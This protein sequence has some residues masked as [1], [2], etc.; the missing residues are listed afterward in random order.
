MPSLPPAHTGQIAESKII[1]LKDHYETDLGPCVR[2]TKRGWSYASVSIF[3][4][5]KKIQGA[6]LE[7]IWTIKSKGTL[8]TKYLAVGCSKDPP[9]VDKNPA[10]S[11]T[12]CFFFSRNPIYSR[13]SALCGTNLGLIIVTR[14]FAKLVGSQFQGSNYQRSPRIYTRLRRLTSNY[15]LG[16]FWNKK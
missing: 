9:A 15:E 6:W 4:P 11:P 5:R 14:D 2:P 16:V 10:T 13:S 3:F 8:Y 12:C 7:K 1:T